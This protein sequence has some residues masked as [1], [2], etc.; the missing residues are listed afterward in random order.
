MFPFTFL[1][2]L[3][4]LQLVCITFISG[5]RVKNI[6]NDDPINLVVVILTSQ[7]MF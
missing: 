2:F 3:Q 4:S 5:K 7:V 1:Y 6:F